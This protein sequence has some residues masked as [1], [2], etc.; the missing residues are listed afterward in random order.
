M[1]KFSPIVGLGEAVE[2]LGG[3]AQPETHERKQPC[4]APWAT[5]IRFL[6]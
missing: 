6:P 5:Q 4:T 1:Q 3:V 2:V